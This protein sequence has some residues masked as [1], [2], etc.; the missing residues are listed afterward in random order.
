MEAFTG[1][2]LHFQTLLCLHLCVPLMRLCVVFFILRTRRVTRRPLGWLA[3][4]ACPD[5]II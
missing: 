5:R 1:I 2:D 3:S 4:Q